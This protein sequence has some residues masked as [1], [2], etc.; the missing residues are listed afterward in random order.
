MM[1]IL[2]HSHRIVG[3]AV[4][5]HEVLRVLVRELMDVPEVSKLFRVNWSDDVGVEE[6]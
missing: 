1:V 5:D 6:L 3:L 4:V 2:Q